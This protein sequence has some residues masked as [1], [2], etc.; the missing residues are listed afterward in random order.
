MDVAEL[1]LSL[2]V[3]V[4]WEAAVVRNRGDLRVYRTVLSLTSNSTKEGRVGN[5]I[6]PNNNPQ[7]S[8]NDKC[9]KDPSLKSMYSDLTQLYRGALYGVFRVQ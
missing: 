4:I 5:Q 1:Q 7:Q 2:S 3:S 6:N 8:P 9:M